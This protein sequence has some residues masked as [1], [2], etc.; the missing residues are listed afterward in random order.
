MINII[1]AVMMMS[2]IFY[3]I[4]SGQSEGILTSITS[5]ASSAVNLCISL[6]GIYCFWCGIMRIAQESGLTNK[7]AKLLSPLLNHMFKSAS[8]DAISA[9]SMNMTSN[10]LGLGNA[11]TPYGLKAMSILASESNSSDIPSHNMVLLAV[12]N[13][14]SLQLIPTTIISLRNQYGALQP[15]SIVITTLLSTFVAAFV[16]VFLCWLFRKFSCR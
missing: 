12:I 15:A 7:L 16:G 11:A 6:T 9:I 1:W 8:S 10:M 13:S 2:S 14:A 3:M 5:G 4:F